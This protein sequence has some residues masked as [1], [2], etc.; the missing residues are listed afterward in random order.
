MLVPT[1]APSP[2]SVAAFQR[3][4]HRPI[5][6]RLWVRWA[7]GL[8]GIRDRRAYRARPAT[9]PVVD[10]TIHTPWSDRLVAEYVGAVESERLAARA[11][12][13]VLG[14]QW[15][16]A[17]AAGRAA[18]EAEA[19]A[20]RE[21]ASLQA[22]EL[23]VTPRTAGEQYD[24]PEQ[25]RARRQAARVRTESELTATIEEQSRASARAGI[26][27]AD[28]AD[29]IDAHWSALLIRVAAVSAYY[30]RRA[31][32]YTRRLQG[33]R[34]TVVFPPVLAQPGWAGGGCPWAPKPTLVA[35]DAVDTMTA[36]AVD[37]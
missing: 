24:S 21:L 31:G 9:S 7:D 28:F 33:R 22:T 4:A 26:A 14:S 1:D 13:S 5:P 15:V 3:R 2:N 37:E 35:V 12:I 17:D 18:R 30:T 10:G 27:K 6:Y 36:G 34:G 8:D 23:D 16:A 25:I 19:S 29:A 32:T 11:A 20:R